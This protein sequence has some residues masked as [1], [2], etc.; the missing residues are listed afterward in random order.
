MSDMFISDSVSGTMTAGSGPQNQRRPPARVRPPSRQRE[1]RALPGA[2][3][4]T[5]GEEKE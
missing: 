4:P 2:S 3:S 5:D 1:S